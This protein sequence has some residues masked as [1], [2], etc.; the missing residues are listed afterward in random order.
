[1]GFSAFNYL[2][3]VFSLLIAI[4]PVLVLV[5]GGVH[6]PINAIPRVYA[7]PCE[8]FHNT[9][10]PIL[11]LLMGQTKSCSS[12]VGHLMIFNEVN[13]SRCSLNCASS[14]NYFATV[15]GNGSKPISIRTPGANVLLSP[16][17]YTVI[18]PRLSGFYEQTLSPSCSGT[19][20]AGESIIC[21]ITNSYSNNIQTW[22]DKLN[23]VKI[24]FS[25]SPPFPFVGNLTQLSFQATNSANGQPIQTSHIRVTLI[26]NV[27][28]NF[29]TS[30]TIND[31]SDFIVFENI[32][33]NRGAFSLDHSFNSA[34][35][36]G[37]HQ[38]ILE[39]LAKDDEPVLASFSVPVLLPE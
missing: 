15:I 31:R 5:L 29:N 11:G 22:I 12:S 37:T 19:I 33:S 35:L 26:T 6:K 23:H 25:Y 14:S 39:M 3:I 10:I 20:S 7:Q 38:I 13:N 2:S 16:G 36:A 27:T 34:D 9:G 24:Q 28:A 30:T 18:A 21:T 4:A 17:N 1:M 8:A 32:S